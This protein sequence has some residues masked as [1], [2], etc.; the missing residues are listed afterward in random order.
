MLTG[1]EMLCI[2]RT[3]E[4]LAYGFYDENNGFYLKVKPNVKLNKKKSKK[5]SERSLTESEEG[6]LKMLKLNPG[7]IYLECSLVNGFVLISKIPINKLNLIGGMKYEPS[8]GVYD[9]NI[10]L[11]I[12]SYGSEVMTDISKTEVRNIIKLAER[13]KL[14]RGVIQNLKKKYYSEQV[15]LILACLSNDKDSVKK[16]INDGVDLSICNDYVIR[17]TVTKGWSEISKLLLNHN[18][19]L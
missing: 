14:S 15:N 13:G 7:N 1:K 3:N 6:Y 11:N 8:R 2:L 5:Y 19:E 12:S 17:Y 10:S 18:V 9:K 16:C 4:E